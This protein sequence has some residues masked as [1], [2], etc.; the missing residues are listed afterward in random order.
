LRP[1]TI[2]TLCTGVIIALGA[3][4]FGILAFVARGSGKPW[5]YWI[6]PL[7]VLGFAAMMA[8]LVVQYYV[9]VGRLES[10]GRPKR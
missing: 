3:L 10:K 4:A 7:L 8:N 9:K 2:V 5:F 1:T 6:A